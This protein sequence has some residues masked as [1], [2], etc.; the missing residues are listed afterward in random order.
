V[1]ALGRGGA[2]ESILADGPHPTGMF[3]D[4]ATAQDIA[5]CV[6]SFIRHESLFTS[7]A[8]RAR[9]QM[10]TSDRFCSELKS[11]V[12]RE[13]RR[14]TDYSDYATPSRVMLQTVAAS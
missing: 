12:D 10:F 11:F 2:R 7:S 9:A 4:D 6:K 8:C 1:L 14:L 13:F 3:F 5:G